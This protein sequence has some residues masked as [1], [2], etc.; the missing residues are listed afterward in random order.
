M[1]KRENE[2]SMRRFMSE[3]WSKGDMAVIDELI[4]PN[5]AFI[6]AFTRTDTIDGFRQMVVRNRE[7]FEGL[8]YVPNDVVADDTKGACWWTMSSRHVG[9]WRNVPASNED[10]SIDGVT[11]FWF[12]PEGRFARAVVENDVLGLMR[13]IGGVELP[14]EKA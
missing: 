2:E 14:Y 8:T 5:F 6:L 4:D 10:V 12:T 7:V 13:Q 9:T 11:F 3:I 1:G